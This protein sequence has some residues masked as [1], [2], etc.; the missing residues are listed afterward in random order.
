MS[1]FGVTPPWSSSFSTGPWSDEVVRPLLGAEV[2]CPD[3]EARPTSEKEVRVTDESVV[4]SLS[5]TSSFRPVLCSASSWSE[6]P[7]FVRV[8]SKMVTGLF[9]DPDSV[10]WTEDGRGWEPFLD[11]DT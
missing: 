2:G 3:R 1:T 9:Q 4:T 6:T 10:R 11:E 5:S 8:G 7:T